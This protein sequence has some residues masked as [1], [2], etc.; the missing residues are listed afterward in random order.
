MAPYRGVEKRVIFLDRQDY[1]RFL[2]LLNVCNDTKPIFNSTQSI[3]RGN[4]GLTSI[5]DGRDKI[6]SVVCFCLMPNHFH[7]LL[8]Q[9]K[10]KGIPLFLQKIG[11]GY[12]MYFNQKNKRSG[13]LFQG[14]YKSVHIDDNQYLT[15][16][17]RYIHL[18]PAELREPN[19]KGRGV[20]KHSEI[21]K[22]IKNYPWS[23]YADYIGH[24]TF[25][26]IVDKEL[27]SELYK[28]PGEYER[29]IASWLAEDFE[30]IKEYTI[31][32]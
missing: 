11:T 20:K 28:I 22:F 25:H 7:L 5:G 8:K 1:Q 2:Y 17:S 16:L 3:K 24:P 19:W 23:S 31:E 14:T 13:S 15:H 21:E 12:A 18:N 27:F 29:F 10:P 26:D 30:S 9:R 4:R 32:V 6:V